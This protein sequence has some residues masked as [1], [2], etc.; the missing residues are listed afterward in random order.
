M[1]LKL[2]LLLILIPSFSWGQ[3]QITGSVISKSDKLPLPG[4]LIMEKGTKNGATTDLDGN[5]S[6][7]VSQTN[8]ILEISFIGFATQEV[9]INNQT[10][11]LVELKP[12]C[13]MCWFDY[14]K[15]GFY[16]NSGIINNPVGGQI[17]FSF[18]A[19]LGEPLLKTG[20]SYQTN[21]ENNKFMILDLNLHHLFVSCNFHSDINSSYKKLDFNNEIDI[22]SYSI[23]SYL[24]FRRISPILG[25]SNISFLNR[26]E[27]M[28][29]KGSGVTLGLET[30]VGKPFIM[31]VSAKTTIYDGLI[32]YQAQID[33]RYRK[34]YG[35]IKYY[36]ISDFNELSL[37]VGLEMTYYLKS[38][39]KK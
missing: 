20:F 10:S 17:K 32:E 12:E 38:Q 8:S 30:Y 1:N 14:Q 24:N 6:I 35:F 22:S 18:P 33:K 7:T 29:I 4:V 26:K 9:I 25:Y 31:Q 3:I 36:R 2:Y 21:L 27:N 34:F 28:T 5:F 11:L 19:F 23:E 37:G 39:R 15:I 13:T 16:I